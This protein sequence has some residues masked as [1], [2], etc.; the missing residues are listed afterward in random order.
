MSALDTNL[1]LRVAELMHLNTGEMAAADAIAVAL[2]ERHDGDAQVI[3]R[4]A[5]AF[6]AGAM[7]PLLKKT[8]ELSDDQG[9][10]FDLP[11]VIGVRTPAGPL[12]VRR[13]DATLEHVRDWARGGK[14][15]H[16]TQD[17]RF[18]R[19]VQA[20]EHVKDE[21]GEI[22]WSVAQTMIPAAA[23]GAVSGGE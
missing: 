19:L 22:S 14:Q 9:V 18:G 10:L 3:A 17:L 4:V 6:L 8:Y 23:G 7:K 16:S 15:H 1:Q 12:L 11:A 21:P 2:L 5:G 13:Q 20:L